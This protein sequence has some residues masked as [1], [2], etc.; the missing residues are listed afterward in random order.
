MCSSSTRKEKINRS[1][2]ASTVSHGFV[3][4]TYFYTVFHNL[5][6]LPPLQMIHGESLFQC[7]YNWNERLKYESD[8][9]ETWAPSNKPLC[10]RT[11]KIKQ[12]IDIKGDAF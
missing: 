4:I 9:E 5:S 12:W 7:N 1:T 3:K 2:Y 11:A 8:A 6:S 10:G